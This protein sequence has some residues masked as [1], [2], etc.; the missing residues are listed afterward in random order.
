MKAR[1]TLVGAQLQMLGMSDQPQP[2]KAGTVIAA[3]LTDG[4]TEPGVVEG[5]V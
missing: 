5:L 2:Q 4:E 3:H 1:L